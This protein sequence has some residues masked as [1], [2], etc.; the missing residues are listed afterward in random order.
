MASTCRPITW[1]Q[2]RARAVDTISPSV[3]LGLCRNR[4][5]RISPARLPPS[6]RT[7]TP[8]PPSATSRSYK[9]APFFETNVPKLPQHGGLPNENHRY[10]ESA[11]E[12]SSKPQEV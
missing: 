2:L 9:K 4:A 3:T 11:S 5:I 10:R 6:C 8:L 7:L 1:V 12:P